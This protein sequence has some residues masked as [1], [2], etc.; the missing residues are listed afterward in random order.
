MSSFPFIGQA[1]SDRSLSVES[2]ECINLFLEAD[3][4]GRNALIG[5]PGQ[6]LFATLGAGP[7]R[8][9][10]K[11]ATGDVIAVSGNGVYRVKQDGSATQ[12][13]TI[14]SV[15]GPVSIADNGQQCMI[16]DGTPT[17]YQVA[18]PDYVFSPIIDAACYG[19]DNVYFLDGR[20]VLNRPGT[21]Q[22]YLSKLYS[23]AF[24]PLY[25][26]TAETSPDNLVSHIVDHRE[27]WL[28]GDLTTE[29]W[30]ASGAPTFPYERLQ[31]AAVE[32]GCAAAHSVRKIDNTIVWLGKDEK[33]QGIIWQV[34]DYTPVRISTHALEYAIAGYA[35]A[36]TISDAVAYV[37]QQE[38]HTFYQLTFPSA[39]RTWVYDAAMKAWHQRAWLDTTG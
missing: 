9:A 34:K 25:F 12:L 1:Y 32:T 38:G 26:A 11:I 18:L 16:V 24:D 28:F 17:A 10:W 27:I 39:Q 30:V 20:F 14:G 37:Y 2:Q 4:S 36:G 19:A 35:R 8:G 13:G 6:R 33:G 7:V 3:P 31:G 23:T 21:G 15:A 29:I 22:F 5:T